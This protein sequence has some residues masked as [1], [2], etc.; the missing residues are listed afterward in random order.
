MGK[1]IPI[2]KHTSKAS[3]LP[4][5]CS[6]QQGD[7]GSTNHLTWTQKNLSLDTRDSWNSSIQSPRASLKRYPAIGQHFSASPG[8]K[9]LE[10]RGLESKHRSKLSPTLHPT[11]LEVL[12][13]VNFQPQD[14]GGRNACLHRACF[15]ACIQGFPPKK[16][17]RSWNGI[18][19]DH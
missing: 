14:P 9:D 1:V 7:R 2:T 8:R 17:L 15:E 16:S 19:I 5:F 18:K 10:I 4:V 11:A 12:H 13:I 6:S 3:L